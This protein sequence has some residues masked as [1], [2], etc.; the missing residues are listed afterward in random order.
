MEKTN[1]DSIFGNCD[2]NYGQLIENQA[3]TET[4]LNPR[5]NRHGAKKLTKVKTQTQPIRRINSKRK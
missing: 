2:K 4:R 3:N 1:F 5:E